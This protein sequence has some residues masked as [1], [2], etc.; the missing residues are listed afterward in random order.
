MAILCVKQPWIHQLNNFPNNRE[1]GMLYLFGKGQKSVVCVNI[2]L[3]LFPPQLP[4]GTL[5]NWI[6]MR[7]N[8]PQFY[9]RLWGA[10]IQKVFLRNKIMISFPKL[11]GYR[12]VKEVPLSM[13]QKCHKTRSSLSVAL[14]L[15]RHYPYG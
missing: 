11:D 5:S 12:N 7:R 4:D 3:R 14:G 8:S 2:P 15:H 10:N 1:T 9:H 6:L 13:N